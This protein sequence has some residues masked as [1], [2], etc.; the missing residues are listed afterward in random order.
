MPD[1]ERLP[2]ATMLS[3]GQNE[4]PND[5]ELLK[6][7]TYLCNLECLPGAAMQ[8]VGQTQ[9]P[10]DSELLDSNTCIT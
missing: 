4:A 7:H 9:A 10:N 5:S 3:V 6:T 2:R 8:S 1:L